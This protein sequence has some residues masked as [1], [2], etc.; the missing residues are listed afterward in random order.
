MMRMA[1]FQYNPGKLATERQTIVDFTGATD[2][3]VAVASVG[4]HANHVH[5]APDRIDRKR[6]SEMMQVRSKMT[7]TRPYS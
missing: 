7:G 4:P 3:G 2:D 1:F 5:L 6:S